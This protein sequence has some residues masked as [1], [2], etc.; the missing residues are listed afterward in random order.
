MTRLAIVL[1]IA[2]LGS[3]LL[4]V[5]TA[6]ESRRLYGALDRA[7]QEQRSLEA[8]RQRLDAERQVAATSTRVEKLARERLAMRTATPAVTQYVNDPASGV[9]R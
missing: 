3:A 1:G 7:Q 6:H 8:E 4:R 5:H 2:L 9:A